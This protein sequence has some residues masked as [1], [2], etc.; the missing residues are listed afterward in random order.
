M[1]VPPQLENRLFLS[2]G[3]V[4]VRILIDQNHI[5]EVDLM[6]ERDKRK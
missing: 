5:I 3:D 1:V 4:L 2:L 6:H